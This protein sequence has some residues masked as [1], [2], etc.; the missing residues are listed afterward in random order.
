[1]TTLLIVRHAQASF[2]AADYDCLSTL[3]ERQASL[4]GD[5]LKE[6]GFMPEVVATGALKRHAQTARGALAAMPLER[7]LLEMPGFSEFDNREVMERAEPGVLSRLQTLRAKGSP[8]GRDFEAA[9]LA[10]AERWISGRHDQDYEQSWTQFRA[11]VLD[12]LKAL[13]AAHPGKTVLLVTSG[14]PIICMFQALTGAPD[15][16][17]FE[18][19]L[20]LLNC[21]MTRLQVREKRLR[22]SSF[23][24]APHL[25]LQNDK[26]ILTYI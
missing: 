6:T 2:G 20:S 3:G 12:A 17:A 23:N 19:G 11:R 21:G 18:A 1:M 22:L 16:K 7:D 14:G 5:W 24:A 15:S 9:F 8:I 4:L 26:D 13:I 25:E 10:G